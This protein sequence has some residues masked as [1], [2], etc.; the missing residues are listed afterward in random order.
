MGRTSA[1]TILSQDN[2]LHAFSDVYMIM[3]H[4]VICGEAEMGR[5]LEGFVWRIKIKKFIRRWNRLLRDVKPS[6]K[7]FSVGSVREDRENH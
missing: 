5:V 3:L 1:Y 7:G 4:H 6:G 2:W